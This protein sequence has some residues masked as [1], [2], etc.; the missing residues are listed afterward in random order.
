ML[1]SH[2]DRATSRKETVFQRLPQSCHP[3]CVTPGLRIS[4]TP[5]RSLTYK[6]IDPRTNASVVTV[7]NQ[8]L[9]PWVYLYARVN[10]RSRRYFLKS[11]TP[12]LVVAPEHNP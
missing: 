2:A 10:A 6:I 3:Y 9:D 11:R 1:S 5:L 12:S 7:N 4:K 8:S